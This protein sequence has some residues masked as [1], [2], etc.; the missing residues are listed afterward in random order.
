MAPH[1]SF[2]PGNTPDVPI[3][4]KIGKIGSFV[5]R[6]GPEVVPRTDFE[7]HDLP[8]DGRYVLLAGD[9]HAHCFFFP[10]GEPEGNKI[11]L[12]LKIAALD[13]LLVAENL[14]CTYQSAQCPR[15]S[16]TAAPDQNTGT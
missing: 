8:K 7:C 4:S 13:V 3:F 14:L 9:H 16:P 2:F 1:K 5:V 12:L 11:S 6:R 10:E 15:A